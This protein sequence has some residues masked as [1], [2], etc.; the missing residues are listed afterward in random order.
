MQVAILDD[1]LDTLRT[2][3]CFDKLA[4]HHV[5]VFTDHVDDFGLL[6]QRLAQ[7]EALVLVRERTVIRRELLERLP[8]LRLIS[9]RSA[10]P[11]IDVEACTQLGI[12]VSSNLHSDSPSYATAELTWALVLAA[13]R[14]LPEQVEALKAGQWQTAVGRTLRSKTLGIYG[15]GRIGR[16]VAGY[17]R[18]FGMKVLVWASESSRRL[19][20]DEGHDVASSKENFFE[21]CDVLSLH[22]RL[23]DATRGVVTARD[24]SRMKTDALFVNASRSG[25]VESG[26]LVTALRAGRPGMAAIDVYD[27]EPSVGATDPLISMDNVI[28]TPHLGY[29]T[30]DEW[31]LQFSDIFEQV[32][33]YARQQP[34]NVVNPEVMAHVR[35]WTG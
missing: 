10:Y 34:A 16:V 32:N 31:Q 9:L 3:R 30:L 17:G 35:P 5:T 23:V 25:L 18:A 28:C 8:N 1:Y 20:L 33:A 6:A 13:M 4:E 29:V 24:L 12:V 22:M 21:T 26:A 27:H 19:A 15:F 11:H 14:R 7:T 2:L